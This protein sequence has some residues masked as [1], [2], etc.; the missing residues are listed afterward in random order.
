MF[1][2]ESPLEASF[3]A[4]GCLKQSLVPVCSNIHQ[5][6]ET[7]PPQRHRDY[8]KGKGL[9]HPH[10][11]FGLERGKID[12]GVSLAVTEEQPGYGG[13]GLPNQGIGSAGA[14]ES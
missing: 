3:D 6:V 12:K 2:A 11:F 5:T 9:R 1:P 8:S 4:K 10:C 7:V 14:L 13:W